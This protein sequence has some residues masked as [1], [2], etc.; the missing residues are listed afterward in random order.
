M[1]NN[2]HGMLENR[3]ILTPE[4][5]D[6][7]IKMLTNLKENYFERL[8]FYV[9]KSDSVNKKSSHLDAYEKLAVEKRMNYMEDI[10]KRK[11]CQISQ[12]LWE[13]HQLIKRD[14]PKE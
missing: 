14:I 7:L 1:E 8:T 2:V 13:V 3:V 9:N 5:F 11:V 12:S 4:Q 10:L 6:E